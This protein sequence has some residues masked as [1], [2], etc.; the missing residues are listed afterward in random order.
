[1]TNKQIFISKDFLVFFI[2]ASLIFAN[3]FSSPFFGVLDELIGIFSLLVL[4]F[5]F[6]RSKLKK[7]IFNIIILLLVL[8]IVGWLSNLFSGVERTPI[9]III[10]TIIYMKPIVIFS[11]ILQL[12]EKNTLYNIRKMLKIPIIIF[13]MLSFV[14]MLLNFFGVLNM[15]Q[16][17]VWGIR[18]YKFI[19]QF[20]VAFA[21][22]VFSMYG[23]ILDPTKKI[24]SSISFFIVTIL[25]F[26]TLKAQSIFFI[27]MFVG[28]TIL[29]YLQ[30]KNFKLR[31]MIGICLT[32]VILVIPSLLNYFVTDAFSPR[33]ILFKDAIQIFI[34][35]FPFGSGFATFGSPIAS[36]AYSPLY[37]NYGYQYL[38]G[39]GENGD[40]SFLNDNF[41]SSL[42]GQLGF[43]GL[44]IFVCLIYLILQRI[45]KNKISRNHQIFSIAGFISLLAVNLAS[46][47]FTSA[48]G[49][50]L[51][52]IIALVNSSKLRTNEIKED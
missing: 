28:T 42:I 40:V 46:S 50:L 12:S 17:T 33:S 7:E 16:E 43:L 35:Y 30:K 19:F 10:D 51:M 11:A 4:L 32:G 48:I 49:A 8:L 22:F 38:Y 52:G 1:M 2:I 14:C 3:L 36:Q 15:T 20:P 31:S 45:L 41:F 27:V 5:S 44:V 47:F 13:F 24:F 37:W 29:G 6:I 18:N 21:I 26:S 39:M 9:E 23:L 34:K 25:I